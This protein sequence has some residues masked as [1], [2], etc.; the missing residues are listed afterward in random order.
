MDRNFNNSKKKTYSLSFL[1]KMLIRLQTGMHS[2][3]IKCR[4]AAILL[5]M[6][7]YYIMINFMFF[8]VKSIFIA[9]R[10]LQ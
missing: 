4:Y 8:H 5:A 9:R 1:Q 7:N 2:G 10:C 6:V 3:K